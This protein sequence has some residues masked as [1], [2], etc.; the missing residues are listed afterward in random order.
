MLEKD[1]D[2]RVQSPT[3]LIRRIDALDLSA[4]Q[5]QPQGGEEELDVTMPTMVSPATPPAAKP[6]IDVTMPTMAAPTPAPQPAAKP[7]IDVTLPTMAA[8]PTPAPQPAAAKPDIDVTLPTM[9]AAPTPAPQPAAK[10]DIDVTLPT[11]AAAPTPAPAPATEENETMAMPSA[12]SAQ[13]EKQPGQNKRVLIFGAAGLVAVLVI[14]GAVA[15]LF[16]GKKKAPAEGPTPSQPSQTV[17]E[18]IETPKA[19]DKQSPAKPAPK[20][21]M[22]KPVP[23]VAE[24]SPK[25]TPKTTEKTEPSTP[26]TSQIAEQ[27]TQAQ[28]EPQPKKPEAK[29]VGLKQLGVIEEGSVVIFGADNGIAEGLYKELVKNEA[30]AKVGFQAAGDIKKWESQLREIQG[31]GP[32]FVVV[33]ITSEKLNYQFKKTIKEIVNIIPDDRGAIFVSSSDSGIMNE[34]KESCN[35]VGMYFR[36][37]G[38]NKELANYLLELKKELGW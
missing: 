37:W 2:K 28:P 5:E 32:S 21:E 38:A 3:E 4:Y 17:T 22:D 34:V 10:P 35:T 14:V 33:A 20:T 30:F 18:V 31:K 23:K 16:L 11:M 13:P 26:D 19:T 9:A 36:E 15:A 1:R 12:S 7:D 24:T 6:D 8:A 29:A 27:T 25:T